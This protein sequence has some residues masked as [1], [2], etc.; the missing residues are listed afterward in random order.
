MVSIIIPAF[1]EAKTIGLVLAQVVGHPKVS[2][3]LVVDDGS[4]DGTA[5]IVR[6]F[7]VENPESGVRAI[8]LT[9]NV[10]KA[11]AME[12]GVQATVSD[13]VMFLDADVLG[14]TH[15]KMSIIMDP[16]LDFRYEM[17]VGVNVRKTWIL[18]K[19]LRI[20]PIISGERALTKNLWNSI[21]K[22]HKKNFMIEIA[23]NYVAKQT[24]RGMGMTRII[25]MQHV[26]K[27][28]KYGFWKGFKARL[29]MSLEVFVISVYLYF[30]VTTKNVLKLIFGAIFGTLGFGRRKQPADEV[31]F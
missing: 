29:F 22:A 20:T 18:N 9:E 30:F 19:L 16:V 13:I 31:R 10:G 8:Q 17:F 3:I 26:V 7:A 6:Q 23:M 14:F 28:K 11:D 4:T 1:N 5:D 12:I 21:P 2:E 24:K 15:Q 25:G 27:E